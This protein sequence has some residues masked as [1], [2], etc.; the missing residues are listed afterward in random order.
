M[1]QQTKLKNLWKSKGYLVIN[2]IKITPIGLPD[3]VCV[4]PDHVVFVES[5]ERNDRLSVLQKVWLRKLARMG[6]DCY[7]NNDRWIK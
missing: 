4:K 3:L 5:K 2:L 7:V 1:N 6:F